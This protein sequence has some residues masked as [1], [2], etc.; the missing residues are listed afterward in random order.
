MADTPE[1]R[2][3]RIDAAELTWVEV[4]DDGRRLCLRLLDRAGQAAAV[5][6]P[7]DCLNAVLAAV[8][9]PATGPVH[10]LDGWSLAVGEHGLLLTLQLPDGARMTFAVQPWQIAAIASLAGHQGAGRGSGPARGRLH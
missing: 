9:Q 4:T 3:A 6:L 1:R 2:P 10:R 8:P 5:S 7:V